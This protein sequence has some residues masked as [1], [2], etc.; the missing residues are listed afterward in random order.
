MDA[1]Y[2]GL[3]V[4]LEGFGEAEALKARTEERRSPSNGYLQEAFFEY[5]KNAFFLRMG[6]QAFRWSDMWILPSLDVWTGHRWNRMLIDPLT[7]QLTHSTG[8][9]SSWAGKNWG[10]EGFLVTDPA[11]TYF[12]EPLPKTTEPRKN[13]LHGGGRLKFNSN[14][15]GFSLNGSQL[16]NKDTYGIS[17]NY[18]F[19]NSVPKLELGYSRDHLLSDAEINP[20]ERFAALGMDFFLGNW[21]LQP[22]F[23]A[24]DFYDP[25][26]QT[27][28]RETLGY[29]SGTWQAKR[30]DFQFQFYLNMR[31]QD[32]YG[33]LAY[34]HKLKN[35]W[36]FGGYVQKYEG[37]DGLLFNTYKEMT[38]GGWLAGIRME[39]NFLKSF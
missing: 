14:K 5:K 31:T 28:R 36:S 16:R 11:K 29:L 38:G 6:R 15:F 30:H 37:S 17:T 26:T 1:S 27:K 2:G 35:N 21:T 39:Y 32:H 18:A 10:L 12:P 9:S 7:E 4:Y 34:M 8:V 20:E 33:S 19:E 23:T 25:M 13:S 22:Q 3:S 24:S